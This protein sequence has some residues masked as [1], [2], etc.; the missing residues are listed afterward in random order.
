MVGQHLGLIYFTKLKKRE[1]EVTG[2]SPLTFLAR[3]PHGDACPCGSDP[4]CRRPRPCPPQPVWSRGPRALRAPHR[5]L[6]DVPFRVLPRPLPCAH[7]R[8][9]CPESETARP[10]PGRSLGRLGAP[11]TST[12]SRRLLSH[13]QGHGCHAP[14]TRGWG[15]F[16]DRHPMERRGLARALVGVRIAGEQLIVPA[17]SNSSLFQDAFCIALDRGSSNAPACSEMTWDT[18]GWRG[19]VRMPGRRGPG[20]RLRGRVAPADGAPPGE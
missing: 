15:C 4:G 19:F 3:W 9:H 8:G 1:R 6:R 20:G 5:P 18:P 11:A 7:C 2:P 13:E 17:A 14:A 10:F 12:R 16:G